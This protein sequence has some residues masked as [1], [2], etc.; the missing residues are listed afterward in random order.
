M[1]AHGPV[2]HSGADRSILLVRSVAAVADTGDRKR[3]T[4]GK[5]KDPNPK[6]AP[7]PQRS[8]E[9]RLERRKPKDGDRVGKEARNDR[10]TKPSKKP[11]NP[12]NAS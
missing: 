1:A 10:K 5:P 2:T 12:A 11:P 3:P 9:P 7:R 4:A 8:G 6:A